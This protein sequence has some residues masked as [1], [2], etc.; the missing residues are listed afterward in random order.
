VPL[1]IEERF[2]AGSGAV[3]IRYFVSPSEKRP[4]LEIL[5]VR[6]EGDY[7]IGSAGNGD[8]VYMHAMAKAAVAAFEPWGVIH[9]FSGL[10]YVWGDMLE[11]VF[12]VGPDVE[13][14]P[15]AIVVGPGCE[16]AV[17]TLCHGVDSDKPLDSL[18]WAFR[19]LQAAWKYVADKIG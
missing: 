8:A 1:E 2:L 18:G 17:R 12:G 19:D 5:I 11:M 3:S 9:D 14:S 16:E 15:V 4:H 6:Y 13:P 7:P 10:N